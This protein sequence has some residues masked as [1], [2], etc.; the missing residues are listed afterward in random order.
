MTSKQVEAGDFIQAYCRKCQNETKHIAV[1]L[2]KGLPAK[3]QCTVCKG[4]HAYQKDPITQ[5]QA[6]IRLASK[7]VEIQDWNSLSTQWDSSRAI[8]YSSGSAFKKGDLIDH[9][10]FGL[11]IVRNQPGY[12]RM[13]VLFQDGEKLMQ[14][15]N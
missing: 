6:K 12:R 15:A 10:V 5:A 13:Q 14:C 1:S 7:K 2:V 4:N 8:P 11:G 3:V 9:H